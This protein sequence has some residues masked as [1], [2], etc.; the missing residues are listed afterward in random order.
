[1]G[2]EQDP[3]F[4]ARRREHD[5]LINAA[6]KAQGKDPSGIVGPD[7]KALEAD[8]QERKKQF[9]EHVKQEQEQARQRRAAMA[10]AVEKKMREDAR[11][12][13]ASAHILNTWRMLFWLLNEA[14][15]I[16]GVTVDM[17]NHA[18]DACRAS[19]VA[20]GY[21]MREVVST[22][23]NSTVP[24]LNDRMQVYADVQRRRKAKIK[25]IEKRL[26]GKGIKLPCHSLET[27]FEGGFRPGTTLVLHG[28]GEAVRAA[29]KACARSHAAGNAGEPYYLSVDDGVSLPSGAVMPLSWWKDAA[30]S[31]NQLS[32]VLEP[33]LKAN[34]VL[35]IVEDIEQ[36]RPHENTP[37]SVMEAKA[38]SLGLLYQWARDNLMCVI[39]GDCI[40]PGVEVADNSYGQLSHCA[41]ALDKAGEEQK[42]VIGNCCLDWE[43]EDE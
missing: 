2:K 7:G 38:R 21:S 23:K 31:Y 16:E 30:D 33:A 4:Q 43:D 26:G 29:C 32:D 13:K 15:T 41:V 10:E 25:Q 9:E 28:I 3:L 20:Q 5:A 14:G 34:A 11:F 35:V 19:V 37:D 27:L 1:M 40:G 17:I 24:F 8:E 18:S 42:L 39:A 12:A 22:L 6:A 36:L